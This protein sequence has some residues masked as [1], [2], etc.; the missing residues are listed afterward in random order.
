VV[1]LP[2]PCPGVV[3]RVATGVPGTVPAMSDQGYRIVEQE[4]PEG[5]YR[6][7][8]LGFLVDDLFA[9][10]RRWTEV[11]GI[12]PFHVL[13]RRN[14]EYLYRGEPSTMDTQI[15]VAQAGPVQIELIHQ[16]DDAPSVYT[17]LA[18]EG[19]CRFHQLSTVTFDYPRTRA[20]YVGLGYEVRGELEAQGMRVAYIDTRPDFGFFTEVVEGTDA[21]L[22][23]AGTIAR[24]CAEWDG[25]TD[26]VRILTRGG[27]RTPDA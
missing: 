4:W 22:A 18:G 27:Y 25:V 6:H 24:T 14:G 13:P 5:E 11:H 26:P 7:M 19:G 10:A 8:Q 21:F 3:V 23:A 9:A 16:Y 17:D 20:H 12:G 2:T 1:V 15:A